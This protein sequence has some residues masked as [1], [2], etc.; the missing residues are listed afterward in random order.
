MERLEDT[1]RNLEVENELRQEEMITYEDP[2]A[3]KID[4]VEIQTDDN[5]V[6]KV[7][8]NMTSTAIEDPLAE[9]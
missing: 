6:Y 8:R 9:D 1:V 7:F 5:G 2:E 4:D 3:D